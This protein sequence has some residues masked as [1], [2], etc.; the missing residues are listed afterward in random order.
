MPHFKISLGQDFWDLEKPRILLPTS[1]SPTFKNLRVTQSGVRFAEKIIN[2][3]FSGSSKVKAILSIQE[4]IIFFKFYRPQGEPTYPMAAL[5]QFVWSFQNTNIRQPKKR[6]KASQSQGQLSGES[7]LTIFYAPEWIN[8]AH[9]LKSWE[10]ERMSSTAFRNASATA[11][12]E[13]LM[14]NFVRER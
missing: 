9:S 5:R 8:G 6:S 7:L 1:K 14:S 2:T 11:L 3:L 4:R 13:C 12:F 10:S